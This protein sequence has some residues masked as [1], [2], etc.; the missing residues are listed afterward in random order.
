MNDTPITSPTRIARSIQIAS[1][2]PYFAA[3]GVALLILCYFVAIPAFQNAFRNQTLTDIRHVSAQEAKAL[4]DT[5]A[6]VIDV[7][8]RALA[9]ASHL[10]GALLI[11]IDMLA[12]QLH[13]LE[14]YKGL[15][16][17]VYS[18]DGGT[19]G[20]QAVMLLKNA[21]FALAFN[22]NSGIRG[23]RAAGFETRGA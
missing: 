8:E 5:G 3:L 21:G 1:P 4:I 16:V 23:W 7:R 9:E 11:P 2:L 13:R 14:A 10:P 19:P 15:P 6:V 17:V 12:S 18:G 22:L 20:P